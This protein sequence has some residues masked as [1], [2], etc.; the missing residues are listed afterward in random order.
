MNNLISGIQQVGIGVPNANE[1]W[2]WY[3]K[4]LGLNVPIFND[5]ADAK[6]MTSY[7]SGE[8]RRRHAIMALN[9]AGG[10]GV[11]IWQYKNR[12]PVEPSFVPELGDLGIFAIKI[13]CLD[14]PKFYAQ[15]ADSEYKSSPENSPEQR[16][17]FW[18][19]DCRGNLLQIVPNESWFRP[20]GSLTGGVCGAVIGVSNMEKAIQFYANTLQIDQIVY[21]KSGKFDD[22]DFVDTKQQKFRRVLLRKTLGETGAFGKLLGGIEIELVQA[23]DR[24]P[25]KIFEDRDWGDAGFIHLCFDALDM[26]ALKTRCEANGFPFTVDSA[27]SFDMGEAAGRFSYVEDPDGTLI[28]FVETHRVPI[29]K[30]LGIYLNLKKRKKQTHLPDWMVATLGWGKVK[31]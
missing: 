8:V 17:N 20:N 26:N 10:G 7:T 14:V 23:L 9:M 1:V 3:R 12:I 6:L 29:L 31:D 15:L 11:E 25:R 2:K 30:K 24:S 5:E 27:D 28:E 22:F 4:T 19:K 16:A 13:K 18:L 21:D